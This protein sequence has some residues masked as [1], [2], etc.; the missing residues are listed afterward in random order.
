MNVLAHGTVSNPTSSRRG[1]IMSC[2]TLPGLAS[3]EEGLWCEGP[4]QEPGREQQGICLRPCS[5]AERGENAKAKQQSILLA[6][7]V[8]FRKRLR[9][10]TMVISVK[11][12]QC[13]GLSVSMTASLHVTQ[14]ISQQ[15]PGLKS[16]G[17]TCPGL[18]HWPPKTQNNE[19]LLE[20]RY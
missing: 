13:K 11:Q 20:K 5:S 7:D 3:L 19:L 14:T 9:S 4:A 10:V 16:S 17:P 6:R 12:E 8:H 1:L 15:L 2:E 18:A